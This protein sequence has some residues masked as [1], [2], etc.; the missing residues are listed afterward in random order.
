MSPVQAQIPLVLL[1]GFLGSGKTTL[2]RELL[3]HPGMGETAVLINEL[4][5]VGLDHHLVR[6]ATETT[7]VLENGCVCCSVRDDLVATL[8][9]LFWQRLTRKIPRFARVVI[10]TTGVADPEPVL[11]ALLGDSFIAERFHIDTV[12]TAIDA[13]LAQTQLDRHLEAV[14][15]VIAADTL[16]MTKVDLVGADDVARLELRL[17]QLNPLAARRQAAHGKI[18]PELLFGCMPGASRRPV[19]ASPPLRPIAPGSVLASAGRARVRPALHDSAIASFTLR[20]NG[21]PER[22][23]LISALST[24]LSQYSG[25]I[26]RAKGLA[27]VG[28]DNPVVVQ[29]V[30]ETLFPLQTM[31]AW[32]QDRRLSCLV[33]ITSGLP[34]LPVCNALSKLLPG[35]A[36]LLGGSPPT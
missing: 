28:E 6:G 13:M 16:L 2:L 32:P 36:S 30:G 31:P 15:Q 9:D 14:R 27:D 11:Q 18:E 22:G 20:L 33:F 19:S 1:T 24:L 5:A 26:L 8:Q 35:G 21:V 3:L 10:E 23:Q 4:G 25:R 29:A 7:L 12:I 17:A 34:A